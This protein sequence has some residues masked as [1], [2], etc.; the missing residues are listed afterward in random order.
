M[1]LSS[2]S[3]CH[4]HTRRVSFFSM[5]WIDRDEEGSSTVVVVVDGRDGWP[6]GHT[7][8]YG[9]RAVERKWEGEWRTHG[10]SLNN[11]APIRLWIDLRTRRGEVGWML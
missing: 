5:L 8:K 2:S 3:S 11:K 10:V 6:D 1:E 7:I 9:Q 4:T